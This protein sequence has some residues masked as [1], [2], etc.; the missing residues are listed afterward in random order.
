MIK[1]IKELL[2]ID[3]LE[4]VNQVQQ[5]EINGLDRYNSRRVRTIR[6]YKQNIDQLR[7]A[8]NAVREDITDAINGRAQLREEIDR[9]DSAIDHLI[10]CNVL[11]SISLGVVLI[12]S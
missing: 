9:L 2:G 3:K 8:L 12:F 11:L 10:I 5:E 4:R 1:Y 6:K 7:V